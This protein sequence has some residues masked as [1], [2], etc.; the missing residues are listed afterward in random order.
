MPIGNG[1]PPNIRQRAPIGSRAPLQQQAAPQRA[2]QGQAQPA[3][4]AGGIQGY[5]AI[6]AQSERQSQIEQRRAQERQDGYAPMRFYLP[7][8]TKPGVTREELE[9]N[10][11]ILDHEPSFAVFEHAFPNPAT[12]KFGK[13]AFTHLCLSQEG[14]CPACDADTK[15]PYFALFLSIIDMRPYTKQDGTVVHHS[16]KLLVIKNKNQDYFF[17]Q[18]ERR[19][20]LRGMQLLMVRN[21]RRGASHGNPEFVDL[22]PEE[23]IIEAFQHPQVIGGQDNRVLKEANED[24]YPYDYARLFPKPDYNAMLERFG[25][26]PAAGS[27]LDQQST[28]GQDAGQF[29]QAQSGGIG[30]SRIGLASSANRPT[31]QMQG[32]QA[33]ADTDL[34]DE[35]PF[36]EAPAPTAQ[37]GGARGVSQGGAVTD[38]SDIPL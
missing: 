32:D 26:T 25:G 27:Q 38:P 37:V 13:G 23:A 28:W 15:D 3:R 30:R 9:A 20:T 6:R 29:N 24:C 7:D 17:R 16:K 1:N 35:I 5:N 12:G 18:F 19:G 31:N 2:A 8:P 34:D 22:H 11:I 36:N 33:D 14:H 4:A 21:D 10:I